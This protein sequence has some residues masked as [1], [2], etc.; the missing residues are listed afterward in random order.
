MVAI[1]WVS[2]IVLSAA[3]STQ[4]STVPN[5][6]SLT[7]ERVGCLGSCPDYTITILGNGSVTYEGKSYVQVQGVRTK[8]ISRAAVEKLVRRLQSE[9]FLKWEEKNVVC[10]DFP[11]VHI[12]A[13]L[14][15]KHKNVLEGCN[16]RGKVLELAKEID[17][18]SGANAWIGS[19]R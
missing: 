11:E 19:T 13:T 14:N 1:L 15:G 6:F 16:S 5:D 7:L 2:L 18:L 8:K 9:N 4:V 10:I 17:R 3:P 12:S